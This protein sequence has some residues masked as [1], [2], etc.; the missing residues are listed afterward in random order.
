MQSLL[1]VVFELDIC[2]RLILDASFLLDLIR[3]HNFFL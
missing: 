3:D 1:H 2:L